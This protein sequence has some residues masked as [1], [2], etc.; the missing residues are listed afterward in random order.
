MRG[1]VSLSTIA[2]F[3]GVQLSSNRL[4]MA[5][6]A[7]WRRAVPAQSP[8]QQFEISRIDLLIARGGDIN[9]GRSLWCQAGHAFGRVQDDRN[10]A[11]IENAVLIGVADDA[12]TGCAIRRSPI[13]LRGI[14]RFGSGRRARR[15]L[16]MAKRWFGEE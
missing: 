7:G 13:G 16:R 3:R 11:F 9:Q 12:V 6:G 2:S 4:A 1:S 15:R 8:A 10:I 14:R 5:L